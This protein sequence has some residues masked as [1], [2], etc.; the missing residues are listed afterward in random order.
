MIPYL[1]H[2]MVLSTPAILSKIDI[3]YI[4]CLKNYIDIYPHMKHDNNKQALMDL[5]KL[6]TVHVPLDKDTYDGKK[7]STQDLI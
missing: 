7:V 5:Y 4:I 3:G 6:H 1:V 2:I